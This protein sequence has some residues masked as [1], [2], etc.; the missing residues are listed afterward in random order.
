MELG[1]P[2]LLLWLGAQLESKTKLPKSY[3]G[4]QVQTPVCNTIVTQI[5]H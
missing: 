3:K 1:R 4:H 2:L 5:S